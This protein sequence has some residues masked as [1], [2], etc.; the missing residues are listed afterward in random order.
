MYPRLEVKLT[1]YSDGSPR[2]VI[3]CPE[4]YRL[5][6]VEALPAPFP[7]RRA[8]GFGRDHS[9]TMDAALFYAESLIG[10]VR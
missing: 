6:L 1:T 2:W 8:Y 9:G 3:V 7:G 4:G 5:P 10:E